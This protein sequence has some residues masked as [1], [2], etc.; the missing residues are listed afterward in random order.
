MGESRPER[1]LEFPKGAQDKA[2]TALTFVAEGA[3]PDIAKPL[4][5][6]GSGVWELA[7]KSRG[8]A[9]RVVYALQLGDDIWVVHAFRKKSKSSIAT[10]KPEIDLVKARIKRLKEQMR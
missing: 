6:L 8:D 5:G 9:Y 4:A 1:L 3:K 2:A 7:I 10:P